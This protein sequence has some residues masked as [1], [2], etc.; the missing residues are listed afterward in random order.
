MYKYIY[1]HIYAHISSYIDI[2]LSLIFNYVYHSLRRH[3][4][5]NFHLVLFLINLT[6]ENQI[7]KQSYECAQFEKISIYICVYSAYWQFFC[8]SISYSISC[9]ENQ[10]KIGF[11]LNG[12]QCAQ[13]EITFIIPCKHCKALN[14]QYWQCIGMQL[15]D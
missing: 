4:Q 10:M 11:F 14:G 1:I 2:I 12:W 15:S 13:T 6:K 8:L 5:I 7:M 3:A 9:V